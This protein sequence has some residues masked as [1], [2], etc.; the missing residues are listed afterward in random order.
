MFIKLWVPVYCQ[1][2]SPSVHKLKTKTSSLSFYCQRQMNC[3][4]FSSLT[5]LLK[6]INSFTASA[7]EQQI[8]SIDEYTENYLPPFSKDLSRL[9]ANCFL[10]LG[11]VSRHYRLIFKDPIEIRHKVLGM[12]TFNSLTPSP[13]SVLD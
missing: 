6:Q 5:N 2:S 13:S 3:T 9:L 1:I 10:L 11:C 7:L 12:E 8:Y 4:K